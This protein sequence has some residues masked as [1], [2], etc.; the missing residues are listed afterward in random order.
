MNG[1]AKRNFSLA[2]AATVLAGCVGNTP[3]TSQP[4]V[5]SSTES[6]Y[7]DATGEESRLAQL[8]VRTLADELGIDAD[9]ISVDT[10]RK[11]DWRDSSYGCPQPGQAY[12][13]V[14]SPG[15]RITLRARGAIWFVHE[16]SGRAFVCQRSRKEMDPDNRTVEL[17]WGPRAVAAQ[18]MLASLL[19]VEVGEIQLA[20]V[21]KATWSNTSLGCGD[22]SQ[23]GSPVS[24]Y[25]LTLRHKERD[26]TFHTD[27]NRTI[28]CPPITID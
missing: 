18:Q 8:A 20:S 17:E 27:L 9:Q 14:I 5:M 19:G 1:T 16:S 3:E 23:E 25:V 24:G 26:F 4:K 2:L 22:D 10:V 7:R 28:A 21:K 15:H 11:V 6:G 13:Q 12:L